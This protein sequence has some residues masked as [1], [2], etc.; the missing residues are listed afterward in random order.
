MLRL[1]DPRTADLRDWAMTIAARRGKKVA[2][3][4]LVRRLA[5]ILYAMLRDGTGYEP[6]QHR[7]SP[8]TATATP[9][10]AER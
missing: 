9:T 7:R 5:E 6:R 3:V 2:V 1:R 4:A 8:W 10:L